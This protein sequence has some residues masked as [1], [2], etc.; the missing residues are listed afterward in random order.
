MA[1][2][3]ENASWIVFSSRWNTWKF[4]T[5]AGTRRRLEGSKTLTDH[6]RRWSVLQARSNNRLGRGRFGVA[7]RISIPRDGLFGFFDRLLQ[8]DG[9]GDFLDRKNE[10]KAG[11]GAGAIK[12]PVSLLDEFSVL[13]LLLPEFPVGAVE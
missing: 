9:L 10:P 12:G 2:W 6:E 7:V 3:E 1:M 5:L 8:Q 13:H 4:S 11:Q